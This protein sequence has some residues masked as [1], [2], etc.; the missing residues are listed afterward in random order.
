MRKLSVY[1]YGGRARATAISIP[2]Q[3]RT[4]AIYIKHAPFSVRYLLQC[5]SENSP[6]IITHSIIRPNQTGQLRDLILL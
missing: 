1:L 2:I 3:M 6:S 4:D 5:Y